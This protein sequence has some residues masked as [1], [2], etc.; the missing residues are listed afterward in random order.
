MP[1][2]SLF[3]PLTDSFGILTEVQNRGNNNSVRDYRIENPKGKIWHKK[4]SAIL[5]IESADAR[6]TLEILICNLLLNKRDPEPLPIILEP[7][8]SCLNVKFC[9]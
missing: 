4:P 9:R 6:V 2:S 1:W 8:E 7:I 5:G 3:Q